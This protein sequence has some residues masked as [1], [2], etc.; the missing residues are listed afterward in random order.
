MEKGAERRKRKIASEEE[1]K[2]NF[3]M[4]LRFYSFSHW[5]I[6]IVIRSGKTIFQVFSHHVGSP[7]YARKQLTTTSH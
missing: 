7:D 3:L 2:S 4:T 5:T 1:R 6:I